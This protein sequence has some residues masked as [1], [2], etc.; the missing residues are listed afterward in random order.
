M[1]EKELLNAII[2]S[3]CIPKTL[4]QNE[5][6]KIAKMENLSQNGLKKIAKMQDLSRNKLKQIAKLRHVKNIDNKSKEE[7]LI[8]LLNSE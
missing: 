4:S 1:S 8:A 3:G 5:L 7:L 6:M 2:E